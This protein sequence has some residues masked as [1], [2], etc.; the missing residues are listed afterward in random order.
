[1]ASN[2][3]GENLECSY[4]PTN[5]IVHLI[6]LVTVVVLFSHH[7]LCFTNTRIPC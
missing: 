3:L 4:I 6:L 7:T 1:M 2:P 5:S